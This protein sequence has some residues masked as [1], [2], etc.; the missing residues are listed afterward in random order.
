MPEKHLMN[1]RL[2]YFVGGAFGQFEVTSISVISGEGLPT[3]PRLF[4]GQRDPNGS[5]EAFRLLGVVSNERYATRAEKGELRAR[6]EAIGRPE[7]R[8]GAMIAIKKTQAWWT[9]PQDERR[10]IFEERSRHVHIGIDALPHVARRLHH[11]R[12]LES[13]VPFDF[14]TWFDFKP[15]DRALFDALVARLRDTEEW[16]YV[17]REVDV[18]VLRDRD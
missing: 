13:D 16:R 7:A 10:A 17:E 14:L 15:D 9:M 1:G 4:V 3:V 6:Q 8:E 11:C 2:W 12:D 5:G 18:R